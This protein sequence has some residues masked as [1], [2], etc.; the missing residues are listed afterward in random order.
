M[1]QYKRAIG[2]FEVK[3]NEFV[4]FQLD[5]FRFPRLRNRQE[6]LVR[7][8]Y[9]RANQTAREIGVKPKVYKRLKSRNVAEEIV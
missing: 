7:R 4:A 1:R 3:L 8:F 6:N 2:K 9:R 5:L